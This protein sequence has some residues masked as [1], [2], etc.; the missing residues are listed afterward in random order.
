MNESDPPLSTEGVQRQE[1][2]LLLARQAARR[3]R[4]QRVAQRYATAFVL[5][6]FSILAVRWSWLSHRP[7]MPPTVVA[8]PVSR[9]T[10]LSP[11]QLAI[12][13]FHTDPTIA[14]R[15]TSP[16][17]SPYWQ[18]IDDDVMLKS[19]ADAGHPAGIIRTGGEVILLER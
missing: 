18:V 17:E 14:A 7:A 9:P 19:L 15:L 10:Q 12:E 8:K 11:Q 3:R 5:A 6:F 2:I 16:K 13:Y 4:Y 1:H